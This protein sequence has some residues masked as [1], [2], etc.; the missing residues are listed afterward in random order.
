MGRIKL[1]MVIGGGILAFIGGQEFLMSWGGG[2]EPLAVELADLESGKAPERNYVAIGEHMAVYGGAVYSYSQSKYDSSAPGPS[3][4][5][6]EC[7]YPIIS[8]S[9]PFMKGLAELEEKYGSLDDAPDDAEFPELNSFSVIVKAKHFDTIGAIPDGIELES[10]L[11]GL[12]IN[13]VESLDSE[14]KDL[15]RSSFPQ[16]N[17]DE[18]VIIQAGRKPASLLKSLGMIVGGV[19]LALA[20][21]AWF[22]VG[23]RE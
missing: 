7:F 21:V 6:T 3:T 19:V 12:I 22:F 18:V 2:S 13:Q 20:G 11:E 23:S 16:A 1:A 17:L 8:Y 4:K 9:H 5:I 10:S 14:E 15:I